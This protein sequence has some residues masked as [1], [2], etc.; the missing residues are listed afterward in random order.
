[1]RIRRNHELGL[2]TAKERIDDVAAELGKRFELRSKWQGDRL[3]ISGSHVNGHISVTEHE[4]EI[5]VRLGFALMMF[6]RKIRSE[7]EGAIDEHLL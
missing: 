5:E 3:N 7:I 4:I 1:M 6:E 2:D